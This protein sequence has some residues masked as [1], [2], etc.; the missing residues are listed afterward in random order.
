MCNQPDPGGSDDRPGGNGSGGRCTAVP[1]SAHSDAGDVSDAA[2]SVTITPS[3]DLSPNLSAAVGREDDGSAK[4]SQPP[5][6]ATY[7]RR[8]SMQ[9][10]KAGLMGVGTGGGTR[11][12]DAG[13]HARWLTY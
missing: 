7:G 3:D 9:K 11:A 8:D 10:T 2:D 5:T 12:F 13:M 4:K 6:S 1:P